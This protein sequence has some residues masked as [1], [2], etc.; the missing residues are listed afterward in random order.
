VMEL[1]LVLLDSAAALDVDVPDPDELE[2]P[3]LH[4]ARSS[5][6]ARTRTSAP[7]LNRRAGSRMTQTA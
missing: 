3:L 5:A 6:P 1:V 4:A 2:P 7:P